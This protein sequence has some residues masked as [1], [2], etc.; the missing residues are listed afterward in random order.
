VRVLIVDDDEIAGKAVS[1]ALAEEGFGT[2]VVNLGRQVP[3]MIRHYKPDVLVLDVSL[4][5]LNGFVVA[6]LV[7]HDWPDLPIIFATGIRPPEGLAPMTGVEFLMKP[8]SIEAIVDVIRR[9]TYRSA[10]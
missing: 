4:P 7:R 3:G 2:A 9:L 5:D 10:T 6:R 8:Y 1:W